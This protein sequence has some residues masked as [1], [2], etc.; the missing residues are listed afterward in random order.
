MHAGVRGVYQARARVKPKVAEIAHDH[1]ESAA[2]MT[3]EEKSELDRLVQIV[4][5]QNNIL[6][7]KLLGKHSLDEEKAD[8][9][10]EVSS[11]KR[12]IRFSV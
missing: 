12:P 8:P 3:D 4:K 11:N 2:E 7:Q 5:D 6:K 1:S 10:K 9:E